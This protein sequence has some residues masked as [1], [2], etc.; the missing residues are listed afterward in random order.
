VA[1]FASEEDAL[2]PARAV[3][4]RARDIFPN[5]ALI[6]PLEACRHVPSMAVLGRVSERILAFLAD[7]EET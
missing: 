7:S 4:P 3:S 2:F 6:E 5:L 1:V